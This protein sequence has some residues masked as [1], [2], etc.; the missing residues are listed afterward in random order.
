MLNCAVP[1][2]LISLGLQQTGPDTLPDLL[3]TP[4]KYCNLQ[5]FSEWE[6]LDLNQRPPP[7]KGE[8]S[9]SQ[10]FV[11]V[12]ICLQTSVFSLPSRCC[13][14][15]LFVWVGVL[16]SVHNPWRNTDAFALL[17]DLQPL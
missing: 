13:C 3:L 4:I 16:I 8:L 12:Q 1:A 17:Y 2:S 15:P 7:C 14:S 10:T 5:E 11:V 6:I 9:I